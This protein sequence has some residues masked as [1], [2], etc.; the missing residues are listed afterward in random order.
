[1]RKISII[2]SGLVGTLLSIY[3]ARRGY[4]VHIYE[5]RSDPRIAMADKG[6]SINL[7]MSCRGLTGLTE[8]GLYNTVKK[9]LVPMR[10]RAIHEQNGDIKYQSFGRHR[11][12]Y[13]NAVQ[14][15]DLNNLLLDEASRHPQ[16]HQYFDIKIIDLDLDKK[17]LY[18]QHQGGETEPHQYELLIGADGAASFVRQTMAEQKKISATRSFLPYGYKELSLSNQS[19]QQFAPEHLH[20]WPRDSY[21]L[22]GNPNTDDSITGS[23]FLPQQGKNSF[24]EL[25]NELKVNQFFKAAFPDAFT[26]MPDLIGEFFGHPT[27]NMSTIQCEPWHYQDHCLLIGDAAHGIVPFF[28]QGMNCGFEDCRMLDHLLNQYQD[29]WSKVMPA[30]FKTRKPNTDAVSM[31]S[32]DNYH[33]IQT[34]I[35]DEH[36][37]LKKRL[38]QELMHHYPD[39][40]I[41]KHV[42]VMFTNTPYAQAQAIGV[43]QKELLDEICA[44]TK[45]INSIKWNEINQLMEQYDKKLANLRLS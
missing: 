35:R 21:L 44:S 8:V 23:L 31:M 28:G 20:L 41:S 17:I 43:L 27:G 5:A 33:E 36:F 4:E 6:R 7:A 10:A 25:D 16:I 39:V 30:F 1:M 3:M 37:N 15:N 34:D 11:D 9:L 38:E 26:A 29:D 19:S 12:E 22:L 24:S 18:F 13:I 42:L 14:R 2:G 40:Y 32:M 45:E